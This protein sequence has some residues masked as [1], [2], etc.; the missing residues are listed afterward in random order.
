LNAK[1]RFLT[2]FKGGQP[3][4]VP[5]TEVVIDRKVILA[6]AE[7]LGVDRGRE[8][9]EVYCDV[10]EELDL[11]AVCYAFS[12]G[13][14]S[15]SDTQTRDKFG[16]TF[17][18]SPHGEPLPAWPFVRNL[19]EA[20]DFEMISELVPE[21]FDDMRFIADRLG[22]ERGCC[23]L[24]TDP[25]KEAWLT[26]GGMENLLVSFVEEPDLVHRLC[27]VATDYLLKA[28][29][30]SIDM[31][32]ETFLVPGDYAMETGLI[33]SLDMYRRYLKPVHQEIVEHIHRRGGVVTK[34]SDG[35][36]WDLLDDWMEVG[37]DGYH[38]VQPQCMDLREVKQHVKGSMSVW[39]NIDCRTLL[40][41]GSEE[42]VRRSVRDT[43][44]IAAPGGGYIITSSNSIHPN[45]KPENYLAMV[46][47]AHEYGRLQNGSN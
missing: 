41:K 40:V 33:F 16:R 5:I 18:L 30:I 31:G 3:D 15:I 44:E 13:R 6:L 46:R 47:A 10:I 12:Q 1:E 37:F 24:L 32:I 38:P 19:G 28:I 42:E 36:T 8:Y 45:V 9:L 2:A 14:Y 17:N 22:A 29:D 34:H 27:R 20:E 35:N 21:D 25:Y 4:K 11:D 39:G 26:L 7:P 43:I 23:M